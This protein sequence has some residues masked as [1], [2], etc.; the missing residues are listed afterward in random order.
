MKRFAPRWIAPKQFGKRALR[1]LDIRPAIAL[2]L[3]LSPA[4]QRHP[5][6][7]FS[8]GIAGDVHAESVV[9]MDIAAHARD[10]AHA[11]ARADRSH[12]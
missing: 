5:G 4:H 11:I 10:R 9:Q 6:P 7:E 3:D 12:T 2:E 1:Q 8:A